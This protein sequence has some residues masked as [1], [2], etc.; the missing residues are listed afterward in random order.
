VRPLFALALSLTTVLTLAGC[1]SKATHQQKLDEIDGLK[2]AFNALESD[3]FRLQK[4]KEGLEAH[5]GDLN[6]RYE[7]AL[8]GSS[9]LQQDLL[10]CRADVGRLEKVLSARSAEA[11]AAMSEMRQAIDRLEEENRNLTGQVE[12]ERIAR[13]ARVAQMKSTFDE[14]VDKMENEIERG[15]VTISELQGRLTVNM[16]E[17]ILFDSGK[18]EVK[19]A[20]LEVLQRVGSILKG[21]QDKDIRVEGHTDNIPISA[22]LAKTFPTNWELSTARATDVVHFLQEKVGIDGQRM[23]ACGFSQYQPV[24]DNATAQG[25]AQ[26][27][28]IQIVLVPSEKTV[29]KPLK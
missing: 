23:S 20:G 6:A 9:A 15:E 5:I 7:E 26:N 10:R 27:R 12:L 16:V 4:L 14:L 28:R 1:V 18:A 21:V 22:A 11:G 13:E 17:R 24:A 8:E 2:S 25:R 3:Y 19:T 29:V